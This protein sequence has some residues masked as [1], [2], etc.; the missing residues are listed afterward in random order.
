MGFKLGK[1]P[2]FEAYLGW[3]TVVLEGMPPKVREAFVL[4]K[5]RTLSHQKIAA[6]MG[7]T[8]ESVGELLCESLVH[9]AAPRRLPPDVMIRGSGVPGEI[10]AQL[11]EK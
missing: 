11:S 5:Q 3:L 1:E 8:V 10:L 7:I 9:L 4:R 2:G 6:E